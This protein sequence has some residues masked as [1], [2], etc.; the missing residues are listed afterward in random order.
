MYTPISIKVAL[1]IL[2]W[3]LKAIV[4]W[5][6]KQSIALYSAFQWPNLKATFI[7]I[8]VQLF[9]E[10]LSEKNVH[11]T[12]PNGNMGYDQ[13]SV[14]DDC[15][16]RSYFCCFPL[17]LTNICSWPLVLFFQNSIQNHPQTLTV[18]IG[19]CTFS[20]NLSRNS[21]MRFLYCVRLA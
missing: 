15:S 10:R 14:P 3:P 18:G 17:A 12:I 20:H 13:Y 7:E 2:L 16:C 9:R 1:G 8:G 21:Y 11:A 19:A 6:L 5:S 4:W